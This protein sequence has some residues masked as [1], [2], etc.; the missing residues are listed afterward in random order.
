MGERTKWEY[1]VR[2]ITNPVLEQELPLGSGEPEEPRTIERELNKLAD[3][4][5][6]PM[7]VIMP[8][9][10]GSSVMIFKRPKQS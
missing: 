1:I 8:T 3:D 2:L 7:E 4:G 6:E 9:A 10:M 5:W